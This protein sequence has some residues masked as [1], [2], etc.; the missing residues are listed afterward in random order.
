MAPVNTS[1]YGLALPSNAHVFQSGSSRFNPVLLVS[2]LSWIICALWIVLIWWCGLCFQAIFDH[3]DSLF[4]CGVVIRGLV[5]S[6]RI[7]LYEI[8][9]KRVY[10]IMVR[11]YGDG[12][13]LISFPN[14]II[15]KPRSRPLGPNW[16]AALV[17]YSCL[18]DS[19]FE[20]IISKF[21]SSQFNLGL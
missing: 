10:T 4:Y 11:V 7:F 19:G 1:T 12:N 14:D 21:I 3:P 9:V 13:L 17:P 15:C 20:S 8:V 5:S 18:V 2:F 6:S 16:S